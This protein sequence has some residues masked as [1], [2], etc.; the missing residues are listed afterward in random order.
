VLLA[1]RTIS[2]LGNGFGRVA[3]AFGV[4]A[5]PGSDPVRLSVVLAAQ[6]LPQLLFVLLGGVVADRVRRSRLMVGAELAAAVTWS[7]LA[8]AVF[9]RIDPLPL[10]TALAF[11]AGSATALFLPTTQGLVPE[12]VAAQSLQRANATLRIGQNVALMVGLATSGLVVALVGPGWALL[13]DAGSFALSAAL[14]A[15]IRLPPR[16]PSAH[17][18]LADL[19]HG[20][21]EF[22]GRQ[23]LWVLSVQGAFLVAAVNANVGVLGP[24]IAR[25]E[26]GGPR[27]WSVIVG[28]QALGTILGAGF[29]VRVRV[30]RPLLVGVLLTLPLAAPMLVVAA[31]L[32]VWLAALAMLVSGMCSDVYGVLV[33][34]T[35]QREVP[36]AVLS[37]VSAFDLCGVLTLAPA[38]LL[39]AGPIATATSAETALFGCAGLVV[40]ATVA[41]LAAPQVRRLT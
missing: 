24:L 33:A 2:V 28:A 40:L 36:V 6:A 12:L 22:A 19:R 17:S 27:A 16:P 9:A 10:L 23:W 39:A 14:L 18:V 26:L 30:R 21:R 31:L 4:L 29:A 3:L 13:A 15:G 8:A 41:A 35:T 37:R 5:L 25:T 11:L 32:P 20:W 7:G 1:A 34:T 38:A